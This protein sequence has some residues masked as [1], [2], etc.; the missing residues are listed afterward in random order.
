MTFG[1]LLRVADEARGLKVAPVRSTMTESDGLIAE[2]SAG[3]LSSR[4]SRINIK[5]HWCRF[6]APRHREIETD[7]AAVGTRV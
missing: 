4:S 2:I 1:S 5:Q 7:G 3:F 6:V